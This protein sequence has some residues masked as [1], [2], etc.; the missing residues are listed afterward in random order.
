VTA[1]NWWSNETASRQESHHIDEADLLREFENL[2][3]FWRKAFSEWPLG[4]EPHFLTYEDLFSGETQSD[5][6]LNQGPM[7]RF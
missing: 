7:L 3:K 6:L 2:D 1:D 5:A 4:I